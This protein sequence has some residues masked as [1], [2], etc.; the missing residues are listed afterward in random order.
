[1]GSRHAGHI[2][3]LYLCSFAIRNEYN[4]IPLAPYA[5][6]IFI[7]K[8]GKTW[9]CSG[10]SMKYVGMYTPIYLECLINPHNFKN[11]SEVLADTVDHFRALQ[12]HIL[13]TYLRHLSVIKTSKSLLMICS[14]YIVTLK[15]LN[16]DHLHNC[17]TAKSERFLPKLRFLK[18]L[19]QELV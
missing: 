9:H 18:V 14:P 6:S 13:S 11:N 3:L 12:S 1:M 4:L 2:F 19:K 10:K 16:H 15:S 17:H 8:C 7:A 5:I